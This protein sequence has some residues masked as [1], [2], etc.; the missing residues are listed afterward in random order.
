MRRIGVI[1]W[2]HLKELFK[3][4]GALVMMF[5]LPGLFGWIFGG[6]AIESGETKPVIDVVIN[7]EEHSAEIFTLLKKNEH[8]KWNKAT[9]QEAKEH[10]EGQDT[11][12]AIVIPT[13]I[14]QKVMGKQPLFDVILRNKTEDYLALEPHLQ[15]TANVIIRVLQIE[16]ESDS[17][18][19]PDLLEAVATSKGVA[20]EKQTIQRDD[21]SSVE[22]NLMFVGFAIMF[23]MFGLSGAASTI[24]DERIG[25][26]WG[27]L[28]VTPAS[29]LQISIGYL[30]AYFLMG[31]IQFA[32]L[33]VAM[34]LLF[35][36]TWG[37]L[38]YMIPFASLVILCV[39]G[40]GLMIAGIVKTKQQAGAIGAVLIVSTCMLGGVYWSID[41]VPEYMQKI[42]LAVPQS[43]AMSGF[44]EII[45]GS[46]HPTTLIR[47][48]LALLA[49]TAGFFLIA[50]RGITYK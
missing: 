15:G 1:A 13:N 37:N 25:G 26:T 33:M 49:F 6:I 43:W 3:S 39:V 48:T 22:I 17:A 5:I 7:E 30:I 34:N 35:G 9:L 8:Y 21:N 23:M 46:L 12:A 11:L 2:L 45:S 27:R 10:V 40:F 16:E 50:I 14:Q 4:P 38:T 42:S 19:L 47:D 41:L 36:T 24:L 20:I 32:V 29:K 28:M 44:K 18:A 31:W